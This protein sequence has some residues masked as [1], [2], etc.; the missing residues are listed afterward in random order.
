M[1]LGA[2][3]FSPDR[4]QLS[5]NERLV[6]TSVTEAL[7]FHEVKGKWLKGGF[8]LT[9][10]FPYGPEDFCYCD[11]DILVMLSGSFYNKTALAAKANIAADIPVP[12]LIAR[13]FLREGAGFVNDVNGDFVF[14]IEL[15]GKKE[16][17]LFRDHV[18]VR[19]LAYVEEPE[20]LYFSSD[21]TGL[22]RFISDGR[23]INSEY[24]MG[25]FKYVDKRR[26]PCAKVKK[27]PPGHYLSYTGEKIEICKYWVPETIKTDRRLQH[28]KML[29]DLRSILSDAVKIRCDERFTAGAHV[30]GGL[31]SAIV[32]AL[33]REV[34][35]NQNVFCGFSWSHSDFKPDELKNDERDLVTRFCKLK[36]IT[37]RFSDIDK[38]D[39]LN[40]VAESYYNHMYFFEDRVLEQAAEAGVNLL[41]SGWGGD[42]FISTGDRGIEID[43]LR[44]LRLRTFL[45]R[46][47][48]IPLRRFVK[49]F[50]SYVVYPMLGILEPSTAKSLRDWARWLRRPYKKS[51]RQA[52]RNFFFYT[53]RR[54]LHLR[55]LDF[56]HIQER[57]ESWAVNG[58]RKG[59]EY[60]YPLLDK[61]IIE[62]ML[63]VPS[64]LLCRTDYF[65]PLLR[66]I[67]EGVLPE[68]IRMNWSKNDPVYWAYM[69]E[70][71]KESADALMEE[72]PV[73]ARN[74]E[75]HFIDFELLT[76]DIT[77]YR[78]NELEVDVSL[79]FR[80]LVYI[81]EI[82]MFTVVYKR[83]Y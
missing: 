72:V 65:R 13:L 42:D 36:G 1:I 5:F 50:L 38:A 49:Y 58:Y 27:L 7:V 37:P 82:H 39:F 78:E 23:D 76:R 71:Y 21:I 51:N 70:L 19:P 79:F 69:K 40:K 31:D 66:E 35:Y 10:A 43:L 55:L 8:F 41:F 52:I 14:C 60:R 77:R 57:C 59:V 48:V 80:T 56:Y 4:N 81:K 18:G 54:Q 68:E 6:K 17:Y 28:E 3:S 25:W 33:A 32:T 29:A 20:T 12:E 22:S 45:H 30:S 83:N 47:P 24:L 64:K 63:T 61:R 62:Y 75:L 53:S 46:N 73:W 9:P 2:V 74:P 11:S 67:S 16:A 44:G 34:Y 26:T 15:P